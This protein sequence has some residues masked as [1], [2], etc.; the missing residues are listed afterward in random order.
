[1]Q[2]IFLQL[3]LCVVFYVSK[4]CQGLCNVL[5][6][7]IV[8]FSLTPYSVISLFILRHISCKFAN[9]TCIWHIYRDDYDKFYPQVNAD[10]QEMVDR[11]QSV[12]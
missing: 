9:L 6:S 8:Y 5:Y 11:F 7:P 3:V 12:S 2:H 4:A 1:M 10:G